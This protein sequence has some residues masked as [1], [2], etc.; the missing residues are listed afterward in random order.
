MNPKSKKFKKPYHFHFSHSNS[1][2][3]KPVHSSSFKPKTVDIV[4]VGY[5]LDNNVNQFHVVNS[6]INEITNKHYH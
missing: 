2:S 3:F 4:F 6:E 5:A 1:S